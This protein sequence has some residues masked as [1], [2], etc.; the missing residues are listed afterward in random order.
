V[1][2]VSGDRLLLTEAGE[3]GSAFE[4]WESAE[5]EYSG[6]AGVLVET[7]LGPAFAGLT[8]STRARTSF[9]VLFGRPL[10]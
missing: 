5:A 6:T 8:A 1:G 10:R 9:Q 3:I 4:T 2:S 7:P